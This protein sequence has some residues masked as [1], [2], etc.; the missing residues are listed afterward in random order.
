MI[1]HVMDDCDAMILYAAR[2]VSSFMAQQTLAPNWRVKNVCNVVVKVFSWLFRVKGL[3][4][5]AI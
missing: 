5:Y 3:L 4:T 1:W 2:Y